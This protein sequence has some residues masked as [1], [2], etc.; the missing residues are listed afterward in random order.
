MEEIF[1]FIQSLIASIAWPVTTII[2]ILTFK[3]AIF[4][5]ISRLSKLKY[6]EAEAS[7]EKQLDNIKQTAEIANVNYERIGI[8]DIFFNH[9][10]Y[11]DEIVQVAN[12]SP[13]ALA[14]SKVE[15]EI[16]N[17]INRLA[18]SPNYAPYNSTL[19]NIQLF[20]ENNYIDENT[21]NLIESMRKLRNNVTHNYNNLNIS[22]SE[23]LDYAKLAEGLS[24][25]LKTIKRQEN[26]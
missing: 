19:K 21:Y 8:P 11:L 20:R 6:G 18:I 24:A 4:E 10:N 25:K 7:F 26:N 23:A 13:R 22:I 2:I 3:T 12:I 16:I 15:A 17:L 14:W 9:S 1:V 5:L